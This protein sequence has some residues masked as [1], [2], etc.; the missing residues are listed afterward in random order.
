MGKRLGVEIDYVENK[1][2]EKG[3]GISKPIV[4]A[5]AAKSIARFSE[6]K[7][8]SFAEYYLIGT[9]ASILFAIVIGMATIWVAQLV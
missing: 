7:K 5:L 6:L 3:N 4:Y 9:L 2:W 1:E 8:R